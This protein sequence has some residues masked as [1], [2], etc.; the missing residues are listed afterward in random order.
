MLLSVAYL[1]FSAVP[2]CW[3]GPAQRV[4]REATRGSPRTTEPCQELQMNTTP[5][6]AV[7]ISNGSRVATRAAL[8]TARRE[9]SRWLV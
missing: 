6:P 8:I 2:R 3:S 7:A 1:A 5:K 4:R 9:E